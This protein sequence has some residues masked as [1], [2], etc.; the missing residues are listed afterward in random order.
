MFKF[1]HQEKKSLIHAQII[2]EMNIYHASQLFEHLHPL[3]SSGK[4]LEIDLSGVTEFDSSGL[5][6]LLI[7][8]REALT[9]QQKLQLIKPST[10]VLNVFNTLNVLNSF[11]EVVPQGK[12][13]STD[14]IAH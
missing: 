6:I 13:A 3:L 4:N 9:N 2:G 8:K 11:A 1:D 5:Q 12:A 7:A 14:K 10:P